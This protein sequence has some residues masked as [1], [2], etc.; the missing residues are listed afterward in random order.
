MPP[1][2]RPALV[3]PLTGPP[4]A[5][6]RPRPLRAR[7]VARPSRFT[8]QVRLRGAQVIA[9]LPDPGRLTGNLAPGCPV[10]LDGPHPGRLCPYTLLAVR[11]GST[12]VATV[13]VY[14]NRVFP[15]L[16]AG[17]LFPELPAGP[18]TAEVTHGRSRF[19]F[20]AGAAVVE[21]KSVTLARGAAALFP[22]AVTARG[23]RHCGELARLARRGTPAAIVFLAQRADVVSVA[24][25]DDIDPAFGRALRRAA[26][27]GV[28]VLA[29][30][31]AL[32]PAGAARAWRIPVALGPAAR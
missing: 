19:D 18:L 31:L 13:P 7:L 3:L 2:P 5:R 25:A 26:R 32:A 4:L 22:D 8:C 12:W 17:G 28:L 27:A 24:P 9:H 1:R 6:L 10:L 15:R 14:A 16:L 21:V 29:A 20:H 11:A 30:A 23:A